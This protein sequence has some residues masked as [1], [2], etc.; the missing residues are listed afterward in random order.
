MNEA[1]AKPHLDCC[2][3][4]LPKF[5]GKNAASPEKELQSVRLVVEG[6]SENSYDQQT[7]GIS[8]GRTDGNTGVT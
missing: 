6:Q 3:Q 2:V 8:S 7:C 1:I 5:I 4:V